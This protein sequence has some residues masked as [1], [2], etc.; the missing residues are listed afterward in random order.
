MF[1]EIR[2]WR[3]L[4]CLGC[5]KCLV[6]KRERGQR[7]HWFEVRMGTQSALC[8]SVSVCSWAC[9]WEGWGWR[10]DDRLEGENVIL[11]PIT[12]DAQSIPPVMWK[13]NI[14]HTHQYTY[15]F[16]SLRHKICPHTLSPRC[17][18]NAKGVCAH[19]CGCV[20]V[21]DSKTLL[22]YQYLLIHSFTAMTHKLTSLSLSYVSSLTH[23]AF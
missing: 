20:Q 6:N 22:H 12:D 23:K 3:S 13:P 16:S 11:D 1:G 21:S 17:C 18:G 8:C 2:K 9:I 5:I 10:P 19:S 15:M 14:V 4:F 7:V